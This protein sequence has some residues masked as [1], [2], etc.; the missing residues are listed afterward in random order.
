MLII[1][2]ARDIAT[3]YDWAVKHTTAEKVYRVVDVRELTPKDK[4]DCDQVMMFDCDYQLVRE[5]YGDKVQEK[6]SPQEELKPVTKTRTRRAKN[7]R[8]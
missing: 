7:A 5:M 4:E 6:E 8:G 2:Y 3:A 1:V